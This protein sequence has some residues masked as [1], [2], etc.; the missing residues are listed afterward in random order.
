MY[1]QVVKKC[2]I[3]TYNKL[4]WYSIIF[5][6]WTTWAI[7]LLVK[8]TSDTE[9]CLAAYIMEENYW[10]S[11]VTEIYNLIDFYDCVNRYDHRSSND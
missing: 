4:E 1:P 6:N 7:G 9:L 5:L 10:P 2:L 8:F 11:K 3:P